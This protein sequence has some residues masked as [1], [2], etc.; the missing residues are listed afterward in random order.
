MQSLNKTILIIYVCIRKSTVFIFS[1]YL[2]AGMFVFEELNILQNIKYIQTE[3]KQDIIN[4]SKLNFIV[5]FSRLNIY[6]RSQLH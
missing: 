3:K 1:S 5:S 4:E 2:N 6:S